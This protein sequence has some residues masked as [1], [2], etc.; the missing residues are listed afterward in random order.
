MRSMRDRWALW[1]AARNC[2]LPLEARWTL[3]NQSQMPRNEWNSFDRTPWNHPWMTASNIRAFSDYS[4]RE[5]ERLSYLVESEPS[6]AGRYAFAGNMANINY[7]RAAPLRR[8]GMDIDL[9]LH[10]H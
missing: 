10:P 3:A 6:R 2:S 9:I 4:R 5:I 8:R 1:R 7:V